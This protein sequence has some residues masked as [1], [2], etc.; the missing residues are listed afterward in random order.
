MSQHDPNTP[1]PTTP[2]PTTPETSTSSDPTRAIET[3]ETEVLE[4]MLDES[5]EGRTSS[6]DSPEPAATLPASEPAPDTRPGPADPSPAPAY[7]PPVAS[8]YAAQATQPAVQEF[9]SGPAPMTSVMGLLGLLTAIAVL[10]TQATDLDIHW[11]V[12]GPVT[13]VGAGVLLV[14]LGLA[15]LRGQ[16]FRG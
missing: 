9:K 13:V 12:V 10:L 7:A 8:Q 15:G 3:H 6:S 4:T 14:V 11:G 1:E 5:H 16:R 2:E